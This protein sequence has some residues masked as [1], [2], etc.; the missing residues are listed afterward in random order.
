MGSWVKKLH[1]KF[2]KSVLPRWS[3]KL[4]NP[5]NSVLYKLVV[6]TKEEKTVLRLFKVCTVVFLLVSIM[7][8]QLV[9]ERCWDQ[10]QKLRRSCKSMMTLL[11]MLHQLCSLQ[12]L[13]PKLCAPVRLADAPPVM[14]VSAPPPVFAP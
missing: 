7:H 10:R 14:H 4:L 5:N 12:W 11:S 6:P 13:H 1:W 3:L 8:K 2:P 9:F